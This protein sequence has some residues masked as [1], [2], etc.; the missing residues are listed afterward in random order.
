MTMNA[1]YGSVLCAALLLSF[2]AIAEQSRGEARERLEPE[3]FLY[4]IGLGINQELYK[5]YDKRVIPL[6]ILG[7]RGKR[8]SV[9]G[10][11]VSYDF[12][13]L[14]GVRFA[15]QAAPRFQGY[16]SSDS[17][18]FIGM[19]KRK[20]SFDAGLGIKYQR[21][22]WNFD[23]SS[24]FDVLNKSNGYELKTSIGR[25]FKQ[26]PLFI[27]PTLSVRYLD[28]NHV[29]YYYGVAAHEATFARPMYEG[30]SAINTS[31][32]LSIGTP[33]FFGGF[34]R[35]GIDYTWNDSSISESPLVER[36]T[37]LSLILLYSRFF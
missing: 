13:Q 8:L 36:D 9:L 18:V 37:N 35:L 20:F 7:Y 23:V 24:M 16:D 30:K 28:A 1:M 15:V 31:V 4:G 6:P 3:G 5:G 32:G 34:T 19:D 26:G 29:D 17:D 2:S 22:D 12:L 10:P 25:A 14:D 11:F 27:E 33:I 21:D